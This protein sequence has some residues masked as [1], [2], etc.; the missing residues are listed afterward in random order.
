M[1]EQGSIITVAKGDTRSLD[2]G[3]SSNHGKSLRS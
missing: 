2:Y 1:E 3:S